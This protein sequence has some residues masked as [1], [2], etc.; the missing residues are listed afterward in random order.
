MPFSRRSFLKRAGAASLATSRL[1]GWAGQPC[2]GRLRAEQLSPSPN[3]GNPI[4]VGKGL[5]DPQVRIYGDQAYLYATHDAVPASDDFIMNNWWVWQSG[6]L[7]HWK[8]VSTLRPEDTYWGKP[9]S[10]CWAT[11]A[12]SRNG[13]YYFY[14]SRGPEEIGVVRGDSPA[15][16]WKDPLGKPLIAKGSTPTLARDPG[17]LQERDGASYIVFGCWDFYIAKL[18]E[19]MISLAETPRK[20]LLNQKMGPY[21]PG[22]LDDKPFLH[23]RGGIYY[24]S[25][26]CYYAMSDN[27]Y[28]PYIYKDSIIKAEHTAP[29]LQ[30]A[31]TFD[32]HGS[33]FELHNQWYFICN[34]QSWPGTSEHYRDSVISYVHY[35]D[36]GEIATI[37]LNLAGVGQYDAS[38]AP[39]SAEDY[40]RAVGAEVREC[41]EGGYEVRGM[42]R[43]ALLLYPNVKNIPVNATASFRFASG[44]KE[45]CSIEIWSGGLLLGTC[46]VPSTGGWD[47]YRTVECK[48]KVSKPP[49]DIRLV[50][51]GGTGELLRLRWLGFA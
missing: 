50:V 20:I 2:T 45:G 34:D 11:D 17:I 32:R 23:K 26:G 4:V 49:S 46:G 29:E 48:L 3:G 7:V 44:C 39:I 15:G 36:N 19:D 43:E 8:Q 40:F 1:P 14:F 31:L 27:I 18:N 10:Q 30:K 13:Q 24:L 35:R 42:H 12:M 21:G 41:P 47:A 28:G 5:C 25:W 22:K 16:P 9:W 38:Q 33:F 6:D 51:R 37:D